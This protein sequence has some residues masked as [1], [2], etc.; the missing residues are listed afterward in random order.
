MKKT[1]KWRWAKNE[2]DTK[3]YNLN[4]KTA[5]NRENFLLVGLW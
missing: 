3:N 5:L 4:I 1:S 2:D